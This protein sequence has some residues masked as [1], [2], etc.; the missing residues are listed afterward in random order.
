MRHSDVYFTLAILNWRV[1]WGWDHILREK[2]MV[3][4]HFANNKMLSL[5]FERNYTII[6]E[7]F[8]LYLI[9]PS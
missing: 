5:L 4:S 6:D 1:G 7:F 2:Y 3:I 9:E 8:S